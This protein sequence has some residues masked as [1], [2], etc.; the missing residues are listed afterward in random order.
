MPC[1][2]VM[3]RQRQPDV[4]SNVALCERLAAKPRMAAVVRRDGEFSLGAVLSVARDSSAVPETDREG[5][6]CARVSGMV[7]AGFRP[8]HEPR[9]TMEE[10]RRASCIGY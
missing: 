5:S 9:R 2:T 4:V 3:R 10:R 7:S 8:A 1:Y 6:G